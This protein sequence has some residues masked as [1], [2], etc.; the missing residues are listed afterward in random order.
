VIDFED[1]V[2]KPDHPAHRLESWVADI[3]GKPAAPL[4]DISGGVWRQHRYASEAQW[5]PANP[6][7]ERRK[8]I[9]RSEGGSWLF[10]FAGLGRYGSEKLK[11][12]RALAEG[13][14][15]PPA[16]GV[17]HGFLVVQWLEDA[18]PL[19][20]Q[21]I[22]TG[23]LVDH[24]GRYL[25]FRARC[26]PAP[27]PGASL[28]ELWI[29]ASRNTGLALGADLARTLDRWKAGL[30]GLSRHVIPIRTDNRLHA[31]EWLI[32]GDRLLKTD[33]LD[34]HAAHDLVG[35][36][37]L[38]WDIAGA[39]VEFGL[40]PDQR[41]RLCAVAEREAGRPL[42]PELVEFLT[43]CYLAFQLGSY[44]LAAASATQD[45]KEALRL[46][47]AVRCYREALR[48]RLSGEPARKRA[49][50]VPKPSY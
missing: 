13:G 32:L 1:L 44:K 45:R 12:A 8:F 29:M 49:S 24:L 36:Q 4:I 31:W 37:D 25:G 27:Q 11:I 39:T 10:K 42:V 15:A 9:L 16:A 33:A 47:A 46:H 7:Q 17:R 19:S 38:A 26:L 22:D 43:I 5:P 35:C 21:N 23:R 40:G 50:A 30:P 3:A 18:R 14:F 2:V 20:L 34:H 6:Q 48:Q 41:D 28:D